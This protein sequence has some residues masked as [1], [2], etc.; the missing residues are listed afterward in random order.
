M[1]DKA[2]SLLACAVID[3]GG[4]PPVGDCPGTI[5]EDAPSQLFA[6][7]TTIVV[8]DMADEEFHSRA[9]HSC[10]HACSVS[11]CSNPP[12]TQRRSERRVHAAV[13]WVTKI[14]LTRSEVIKHCPFWKPVAE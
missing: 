1:T 12:A 4:T 3:M 13:L 7:N 8:R 6:S 2:D 9:F 11:R 10:C 14:Q 5:S